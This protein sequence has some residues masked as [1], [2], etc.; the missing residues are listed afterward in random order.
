M[1]DRRKEAEKRGRRGEYLAAA[2]LILKGYSIL[3]MRYKTPMGEIDII[4]RRGK[5][6]AFIEVKARPTT[7]DAINAITHEARRR[8]CNAGA[9][10][11]AR[12]RL[13]NFDQR[14]DIIAICPRRWPM[15][16]RDAW[17]AGD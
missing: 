16:V 11:L 13:D 15:H 14:Y 9:A 6:I 2:A 8:I 3:E 7:E 17:R 5:M 10:Y 12:K 1:T 4:A